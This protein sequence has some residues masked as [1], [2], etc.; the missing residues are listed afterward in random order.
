MVNL[1]MCLFLI[2]SAPVL[3]LDLR[4]AGYA[5]GIKYM[6][7]F[8]KVG[9]PTDL[10]GLQSLLGKFMYASAHVPHYKQR[11]HAIEKLLMCK[12]EV[13]WTVECTQALNDL[14]QCVQNRV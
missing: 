9:I 4:K 13:R 10:K 12:G 11:V 8:H 5:L 3:G 2:I 6:G 1:R 7:N 14:L